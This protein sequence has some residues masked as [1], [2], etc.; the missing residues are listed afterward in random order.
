[1]FPKNE[2]YAAFLHPGLTSWRPNGRPLAWLAPPDDPAGGGGEDPP[3]PEKKYTKDEVEK[4][5]EGRLKQFAKKFSDY[6]D[7]KT[8]AASTGELEKKVAELSAQLED[9]G[10]S[11]NEVEVNALRRD[12]ESV[13]TKLKA[14]LDEKAKIAKEKADAE[15]A[16]E[17]S[18]ASYRNLVL[19]Q[20]VSAALAK[21]KALPSALGQG[22]KL[23]IAESGAQYEEAEDGNVSFTFKIGDSTFDDPEKA[24]AHWL[25]QNPHFAS[26][27]A[28]GSGNGRPNASGQLSNDQLE[29]MGT[30]SLITHGLGQKPT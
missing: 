2:S 16:A 17:A 9:A 28:G 24:A 3:A 8:K 13:K 29:K 5:I 15:T 19:T 11:K 25:K 10:K 12:L 22:A 20:H 1:M 26:A 14:E 27:P 7:L 30:T 23:L 6:D 18:R 4:M 21:S